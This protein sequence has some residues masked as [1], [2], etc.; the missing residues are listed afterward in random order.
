MN[1][2]GLMAGVVFLVMLMPTALATSNI[3]SCDQ[4]TLANDV[5]LIQNDITM[6]ADTPCWLVDND[7]VVDCQNHVLEI[8]GSYLFGGASGK[9]WLDNITLKNCAVNYTGDG[10]ISLSQS[11]WL[12]SEQKITNMLI[13]NITARQES[14]IPTGMTGLISLRIG[15]QP[16]SYNVT[17][18]DISTLNQINC[19]STILVDKA[20]NLSIENIN[21]DVINTGTSQGVLSIFNST[22]TIT[23][24]VASTSGDGFYLLDNNNFTIG[25]VTLEG[26][27]GTTNRGIVMASDSTFVVDGFE[28]Y[29]YSRGIYIT[30]LSGVTVRNGLIYDINV[31][32]NSGHSLLVHNAN[33]TLIE[34][35]VMNNTY[36]GI[37]YIGIGK[38]S[39]NHIL[40]NVTES[41]SGLSGISGAS[42]AFIGVNNVTVSDSTFTENQFW[43]LYIDDYLYGISNDNILIYNNTV[44]VTNGVYYN[45][46]GTINFNDS[47]YGNAWS[48]YT[49]CDL[50]SDGIGETPYLVNASNTTYD[51]LPLTSTVCNVPNI[52]VSLDILGFMFYPNVSTNTQPYYMN[53][54][55][56]IGVKNCT[57]MSQSSANYTMLNSSNTSWYGSI[58]PSAS[59]GNFNIE[60]YCESFDGT[61]GYNDS[62]WLIYDWTSPTL[63]INEPQ[64]TSYPYNTT[65]DVNVTFTDSYSPVLNWSIDLDDTGMINV[66]LF[67][68]LGGTLEN[69]SSGL[70]HFNVS[71][72]D[73]AGNVNYTD[74]W[75][76]VLGTSPPSVP[77]F[78]QYPILATIPIVL[79]GALLTGLFGSI[80]LS[81]TINL[82]H[83]VTAVVAILVA[84]IFI[85]VMYAV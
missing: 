3:T 25:N 71:G 33:D 73:L 10:E 65:I 8:N 42:V 36:G 12:S 69:V 14:V 23:N 50:D 24:V 84:V 1:K 64:N 51:Y 28:V 21:L 7:T 4:T 61:I 47:A 9:F 19:S 39:E 63:T 67:A 85:G 70:H 77:V 29:N 38:R 31:S 48:D 34:N 74:I 40:R 20:N 58:L 66:G 81:G 43:D 16:R 46:T 15:T 17:I 56:D 35:V 18:K 60:F 37:I 5:Y 52:T 76:T 83:L 49:G 11:F 27:N 53:I 82:K 57:W 45:S 30:A 2:L 6:P 62:I 32:G 22:G 13:E 41:Y 44:D 72:V 78:Q 55:T 80:L 68:D 54:T 79:I 59:Q 26:K 75:F